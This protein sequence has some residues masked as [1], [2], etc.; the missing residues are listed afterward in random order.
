MQNQIIPFGKYKGKPLDVLLADQQ[1]LTWLSGQP[2]V[3][4]KYPIIQTLIINNFGEPDE[5]PEHNAFQAAFFDEN[6]VC[7]FLNKY[8]I[9]RQAYISDYKARIRELQEEIDASTDRIPNLKKRLNKNP[10][11]THLND[12]IDE[13]ETLIQ[14]NKG[15][16]KKFKEVVSAAENGFLLKTDTYDIVSEESG[17]DIMLKYDGN[18][19]YMPLGFPRFVFIELK[20]TIGDDF[21]GVL[22]QVKNNINR[23]NTAR[24]QYSTR[25]YSYPVYD[26]EKVFACV[27]KDFT[28]IGA[29]EEN[30]RNQFERS[31]IKFI[32]LTG[33]VEEYN[34]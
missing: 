4:E 20:P 23:V 12:E 31:G 29:N 7:A 22:R 25:R 10:T 8:C 30:V 5:T 13:C 11:W 2:W 9:D 32:R 24:E 1:Y 17:F 33:G 6:V 19:C 14:K 16:I 15:V 21:P 26:G 3:K 18:R 28:A 27:Y 34:P